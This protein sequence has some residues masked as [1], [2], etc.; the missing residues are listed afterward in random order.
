[1]TKAAQL[2]ELNE[3]LKTALTPLTQIDIGTNKIT[4]TTSAPLNPNVGDIW[5]DTD[6]YALHMWNSMA[7]LT[8]TFS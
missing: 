8:A 3:P 2:A 6:S 1:M 5:V 4:W 7:W